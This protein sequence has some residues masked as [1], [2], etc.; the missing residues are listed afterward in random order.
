MTAY[1]GVHIYIKD[2]YYIN[3]QPDTPLFYSP[4]YYQ[5]LTTGLGWRKVLGENIYSG[6]VDAGQAN[7]AGTKIF[8]G[9]GRFALDHVQNKAITYGVALGTDISAASNYQYYYVDAHFKYTF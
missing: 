4:Q 6:W 1:E 7:A 9:S 8:A 3:S 2:R 5:R